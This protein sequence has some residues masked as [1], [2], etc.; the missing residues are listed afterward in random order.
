MTGAKIFK[1]NIT[2]PASLI[3]DDTHENK[4]AKNIR[5]KLIYFNLSAH[6]RQGMVN[7]FPFGETFLL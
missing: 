2:S 3:I 7:F 1:N 6:L 5:M 4:A